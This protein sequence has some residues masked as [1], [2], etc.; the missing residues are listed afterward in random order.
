MR[1]LY[2]NTENLYTQ[3]THL[4]QGLRELGHEVIEI[5]EKK[6]AFSYKSLIR[7]LRREV[8]PDDVVIVGYPSPILAILARFATTRPIVFNATASQWEAN[9]VSRGDIGMLG[10]KALRS[11]VID[12]LSFHLSSKVLLE[13]KEQCRYV[14]RLFLVPKSKLVVS[15][16]GVDERDFFYE[17][18]PKTE[19]F[20]VLF[21]GRFLPESGILTVLEAA[22]LLEDEGVRFLVIG[23]GF[24]YREY[25][26]LVKAL[27]PKNVTQL[28]EWI[29]PAELRRKML[30]CH[31]S[32]GQLAD[33]PRLDRTLPCKL[34]ES[35]ALK[36]P[37]LTGRNKGAME[38]LEDGATCIAANP[39]DAR[40]LAAKILMLRDDAML[41]DRI[42][43]AGYE[44]YK[45]RLTSKALAQDVIT[46]LNLNSK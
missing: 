14:S 38:I 23:H 24:M 12:L 29:P 2:L 4:I 42:A 33:H 3:D 25:N 1:F 46:N 37:Y 34:F 30:E 31:A 22:K 10:I 27:Q 18:T 45:K 21:R 32:L 35:L 9:V 26:A 17:P 19:R 16:S 41:R 6:Q 5:T 13:S 39:S 11:Y 44:L 15:Y 7:S 28:H 36:L 8:R 20:T 43:Q 40:D